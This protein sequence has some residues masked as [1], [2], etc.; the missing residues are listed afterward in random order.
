MGRQI[1]KTKNVLSCV[2]ASSA[3]LLMHWSQ[4]F[5]LNAL[6]ILAIIMA[7]AIA[8]VKLKS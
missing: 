2:K 7:F 3:M 6:K 4:I 5:A 8:N 1:K